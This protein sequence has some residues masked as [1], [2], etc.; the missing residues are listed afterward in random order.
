MQQKAALTEVD[1]EI[2]EQLRKS[3]KIVKPLTPVI[4]N[5]DA[6]L[7]SG[8]HRRLADPD[9]PTTVVETKDRKEELL[10]TIHSNVQR[11]VPR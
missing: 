5:Q 8:R 3:S 9:W 2:V 7:L 6:K 11:R 4:I 10:I 1:Q